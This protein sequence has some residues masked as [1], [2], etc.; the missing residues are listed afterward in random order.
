MYKATLETDR[1][2]VRQYTEQP[3]TALP[4][5]FTISRQ[6]HKQMLVRLVYSSEDI[7]IVPQCRSTISHPMRHNSEPP[8]E[9][10]GNLRQ[11][12]S[13]MHPHSRK[14][15]TATVT[16]SPGGKDGLTSVS[17]DSSNMASGNPK[18]DVCNWV[19]LAGRGHARA[20]CS[21]R[22]CI[23]HQICR[24]ITPKGRSLGRCAK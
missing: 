13:R 22:D 21:I 12:V 10:E 4:Q 16:L 15:C 8:L 11:I 17:W 3:Q 24:G 19:S 20:R 23:A 2:G 18:R 1:Q 9:V 5:R 7:E 14:S 6:R